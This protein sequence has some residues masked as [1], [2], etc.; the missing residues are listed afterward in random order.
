MMNISLAKPDEVPARV[1]E[2]KLGVAMRY[3]SYLR[4]G[5]VLF[6]GVTGSVSYTPREEDDV[7]MFL[8][9]RN[10][11]LWVSLFRAYFTRT[12]SGSKDICL[13]LNMDLSYAKYLFSTSNDPLM[14]SDSVHVIPLLGEE[15]YSRLLSLSEYI[16]QR[17]PD[18]ADGS[19]GWTDSTSPNL[20]SCLANYLFF[21]TLGPLVLIKAMVINWARK[22]R[23]EEM[24]YRTVI[25]RHCLFYDNLK[26]AIIRE[27]YYRED[28]N[29]A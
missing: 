14:A 15:V 8:I 12:I 26:Y 1:K 21:I 16:M 3:S 7:D 28:G 18:K 17:Y 6:L 11:S 25:G 20:L 5:N 23:R 9:S 19:P 13:S 24:T 22:G 4:S 2:D 10:H 27:R 29:H